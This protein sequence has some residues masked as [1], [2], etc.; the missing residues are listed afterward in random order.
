MVQ[1][2]LADHVEVNIVHAIECGED[3]CAFPAAI[4]EL[5]AQ[6]RLS[7][8]QV[9]G[10]GDLRR[11]EYEQEQGAVSAQRKSP[12]GSA[13]TVVGH[14]DEFVAWAVAVDDECSD[15]A[16]QIVLGI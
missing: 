7:R 4:G 12:H 2:D 5:A 8:F 6:Q 3:V 16:A 14:V 9:T 10:L 1:A 15:Q 11:P 13:G